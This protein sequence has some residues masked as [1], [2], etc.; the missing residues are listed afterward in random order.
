M[1]VARELL[2]QAVL[3]TGNPGKAEEARLACGFPIAHENVDLP[4]IQGLDLIEI[5]EAKGREAWRRLGRPLVVE[6]TGLE[7]GAFNGFPGPLVKWM[8]AALGAEGLAR[9]ALALGDDRAV[10]RCALIYV[11]ADS[12]LVAEGRTEGVL[13]ATARGGGGFGWDPVFVPAGESLTYAE[14]AAGRKNE[15]GHRGKA[16]RALIAELDRRPTAPHDE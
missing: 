3:V 14:L 5:L 2:A 15:I 6:E 13:V 8:L 9:A 10:A 16:W 4:E 11:E 1:T 7:L 12:R